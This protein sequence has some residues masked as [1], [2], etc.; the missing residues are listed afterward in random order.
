MEPG[1]RRYM[2]G[3][4]GRRGLDQLRSTVRV[5]R[6]EGNP[7]STQEIMLLTRARPL[8]G[9]ALIC[10]KYYPRKERWLHA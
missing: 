9:E 8:G 7:W 1:Y 10:P 4:E 6:S 2:D 3:V 5:L